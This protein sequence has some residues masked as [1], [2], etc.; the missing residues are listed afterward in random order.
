MGIFELFKNG[1]GEFQ[2][3]APRLEIFKKKLQTVNKYMKKF[4]SGLSG[5]E[6]TIEGL[7]NI[8]QRLDHAWRVCKNWGKV[9]MYLSNQGYDKSLI[10]KNIE[11]KKKEMKHIERKKKEME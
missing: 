10:Q 3:Y 2:H 7:P 4:Q 1:E 6:L 5:A 11:R 8:K 9:E